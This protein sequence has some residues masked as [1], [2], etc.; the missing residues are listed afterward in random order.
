MQWNH[1]AHR[2]IAFTYNQLS[3]D[4]MKCCKALKIKR[5]TDTDITM[6]ES[7]ASTVDAVVEK[8]LKTY[9]KSQKS[10]FRVE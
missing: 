3:K 9:L 6:G 1:H 10:Q 5:T 7:A 4:T 8:R 2:A